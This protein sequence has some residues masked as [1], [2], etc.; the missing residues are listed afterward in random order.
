MFSEG[1]WGT[2]C[3]DH[4]GYPDARVV[5][6]QLGYGNNDEG[7]PF[8]VPRY[9]WARNGGVQQGS[10]SIFLD[11]MNCNGDE[12][13]LFTCPHNGVSNHNCRHYEDAGVDCS[14][15]YLCKS[16]Q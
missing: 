9:Q 14:S 12:S 4:W 2:V 10:G 6:R 15:V 8:G 5:C 3:D 1:E 7:T 11:N 13:D 16:L